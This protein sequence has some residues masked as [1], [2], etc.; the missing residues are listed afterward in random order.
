[1]ESN[2]LALPYHDRTSA[3][4]NAADVAAYLGCE[5]DDVTCMMGKSM[6]EILDAQEHAVKLDL[7]N[8]FLNFVP[9]SPM[10]EP[11]GE[12]PDQP[13]YA[14]QAGK[15]NPMPMLQGSLYDEGQLFVYELFTKPLGE[16][17]YKGAVDAIFGVERGK[18]VLEMY[19]FDIVPGSTDGREAMNV[20]ATD[21]MFYCPLRNVTK[22]YQLANGVEANPSYV[23]RFSHIMS[24]D[25][26]GENY[27]FCV[28]YCC[29][30]SDLPFVFNV[31]SDGVSV[32]YDPTPQE[33]ELTRDMSNAWANFI[34]YGNPN[35]GFDI[36]VKYPLYNYQDDTILVLDQPGMYTDS[37]VRD[38]YCDLWDS[39]GYIY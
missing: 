11:N 23:Y 20:F 30:G 27:T 2:P 25:C 4:A 13:L 28:G 1:M 34:I 36:P 37:H 5:T 39:L 8:L 7:K 14:L 33:T 32:D 16:K 18:Q 24:F 26:W 3:A 38:S 15:I 35:S 29:H 22:S 17:E 21:L 31:F 19:P 12:L 9:F 10:V 6:E